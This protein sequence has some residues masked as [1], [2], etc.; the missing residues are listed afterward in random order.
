[1]NDLHLPIL[2]RTQRVILSD[3]HAV[4]CMFLKKIL[5]VQAGVRIRKVV[6]TANYSCL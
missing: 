3:P 1:M 5:E 6:Y 2:L 4:L